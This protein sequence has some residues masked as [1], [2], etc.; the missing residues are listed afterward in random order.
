MKKWVI[1]LSMLIA[2]RAGA[3]LWA[4]RSVNSG[5]YLLAKDGEVCAAKEF[6]LKN[7]AFC[8]TFEKQTDGT[9]FIRNAATEE[10]LGSRGGASLAPAPE[11]WT[12]S[13]TNEYGWHRFE[14]ESG[15]LLKVDGCEDWKVEPIPVPIDLQGRGAKITWTEYQAE[16]GEINGRVAGPSTDPS[17]LACEAVGRMAVFLEKDGD[18]VAWTVKESAD[19]FSI[20]YSIPD[21]PEGGGIDAS[22]SL[23]ING[24]KTES[25]P[26]TSRYSWIYG[27]EHRGADKWADN[28]TNGTARAKIYDTARFILKTPVK[29]DD[30]LELRK[31]AEDTAGLYLIDMVELEKVPA[32][33]E[34]PDGY[35][36]LTRFGAIANDGKDDSAALKKALAEAARKKAPGVWIPAGVFN[37]T[38]TVPRSAKADKDGNERFVLNDIHLQGAGLWH[39]ELRGQGVAFLCEGSHIRVS[40]MAFDWQGTS[41]NS[42]ILFMGAV[43]EDSEFWNLY[44]THCALLLS[45]NDETSRNFV[46]RDSRLRSLFAGGINLRGGHR[47]ALME[48]IHVRGTGDDGL[49][50][51][52]PGDGAPTRD[53]TIRNCTVES[54]WMANCYLLAGGEGSRLE[55]CVA[56]DGVRDSGIR[57]TTQIYKTPTQAFTGQTYVSNNLL[58][59]CGS[60]KAGGSV[61]MDAHGYDVGLIQISD[62]DIYSAPYSAVLV[63]AK[64]DKNSQQWRKVA[65]AL[66][67]V[68]IHGAALFGIHI[69]ETASGSVSIDGVEYGDVLLDRVMNKS[70]KMEVTETL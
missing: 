27:T 65:A 9:V 17:D 61:Q 44:A 22:L 15:R 41:R 39:T 23:Y 40:D 58:I 67:N 64:E 8:W 50:F 25:L 12:P 63:Y 29:A 55:N 59:R 18:S 4:L 69:M 34:M 31:D 5:E 52:S 57:I 53:C 28:P 11:S 13:C 42:A 38:N 24:T 60:E 26:L 54:P 35:L 32:P 49:I 68:R 43:G 6:S 46:I 1:Y 37:F 62:C 48:N 2:L 33:G 21:A 56:K 14:A 36:G 3:E 30:R 19:G 47:S 16:E 66:R 20:R 51:W 45:I 10:Y 7:R 70:P